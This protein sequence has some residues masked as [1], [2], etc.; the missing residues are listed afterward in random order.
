M[1]AKAGIILESMVGLRPTQQQFL[2]AVRQSQIPGFTSLSL[3]FYFNDYH[4]VMA[5]EVS[6]AEC[7]VPGPVPVVA[8]TTDENLM[9]THAHQYNIALSLRLQAR[10]EPSSGVI[11]QATL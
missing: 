2:P 5:C 1:S 3:H 10:Y 11:Q 9:F 8:V 4:A 6:A 7:G